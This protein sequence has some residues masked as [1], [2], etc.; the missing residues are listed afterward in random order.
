MVISFWS[1]QDMIISDIEKKR[2]LGFLLS[3]F[4]KALFYSIKHRKE[5]VTSDFER[6]YFIEIG[7]FC[8]FNIA[9]YIIYS[10]KNSA[11]LKLIITC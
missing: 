8:L 6:D 4:M 3:M 11:S 9:V 5:H 2:K 1:I 10:D 7:N